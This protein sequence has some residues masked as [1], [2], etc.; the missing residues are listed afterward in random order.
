MEIDHE[1]FS[2]VILILLL[3]QEGLSVTRESMC[4]KYRLTAWES[5][6]RKRKIEI[7]L[8]ASLY[9]I[10]SN[11]GTTKALIRLHKCAGWSASLLFSNP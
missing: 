4:T 3:I 9:I 7:L 10:L 2:T 11:Q 1:I 5:L 6:P 8:V